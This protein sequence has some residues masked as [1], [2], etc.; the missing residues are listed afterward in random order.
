M[1]FTG[2]SAAS[3]LCAEHKRPTYCFI[4]V[5][6]SVFL[7]LRAHVLRGQFNVSVIDYIRA[8]VS[9]SPEKFRDKEAQRI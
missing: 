4:H 5:S 1:E 9:V 6:A 3:A 7:C 2:S 8:A